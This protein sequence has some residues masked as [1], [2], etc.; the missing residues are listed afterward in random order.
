MRLIERF[1][2]RFS[3]RFA[4]RFSERFSEFAE[5]ESMRSHRPTRTSALP[6]PP[7]PAF[8]PPLS[9]LFDEFSPLQARD[10]LDLIGKNWRRLVD[11]PI[12]NFLFPVLPERLGR[13][14]R[15]L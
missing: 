10:D 15:L 3:E 6:G 8:R 13:G 2:E 14:L 12:V 1:S 9:F 4:E 11:D 7:S 5:F